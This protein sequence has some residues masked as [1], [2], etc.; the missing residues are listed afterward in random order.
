M[1]GDAAVMPGPASFFRVFWCNKWPQLNSLFARGGHLTLESLL[2]SSIHYLRF[3]EPFHKLL[4]LI[5]EFVRFCDNSKLNAARIFSVFHQ[6]VYCPFQCLRFAI[7]K[8]TSTVSNRFDNVLWGKPFA[9][10]ATD[11]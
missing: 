7:R 11:F 5:N 4:N 3:I 1:S 10:R 8:R 6:K 9:A 2:V